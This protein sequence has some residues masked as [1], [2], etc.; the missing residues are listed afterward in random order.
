MDKKRSFLNVVVSIIFKIIVLVVS[1]VARR[2]LIK[3]VGNEVNG[4]NSLYNSIVGFLSVAELGVGVAI[5]Y[6]MYKPIVVK[7]DNKVAALYQ[8]FTKLY[9]IIGAIILIAGCL[10]MSILP[11]LA[12]DYQDANVNIYLTFLLFL[13]SVVIS[14]LFSSKVSLI[15]A[16]KDNYITTAVNSLGLIMQ[17]VLQIVVLI[18]TK[19]FVWYLC[20]HIFATVVQ[21]IAIE[22]ISRK[23]H[24]NIIK[25]KKQKIDA[26]TKKEVVRYVKAMF[27]HKI[28]AVLV[29][30]IDSLIISAFLGV[31]ILG[32][33]S[34]Y[35]TI[36]SAMTG[37]IALFFGPLT[38]IIGHSFLE[39][40][41]E[42]SREYHKA[43]H[44]FN[45]ILAIV[46]FLG[47][48]AVI[49]NLITILLGENLEMV[50]QV[51]F[52]ITLNNFIIFMRQATWLFSD[53]TGVNYYSRWS[54]IVESIFN[55][56]LSILFVIVF[57]KEYNVVGVIVATIMTNLFICHIVEPHVLYKYAF[58]KNAKSYYLC[59]YMY[60]LIFLIAL[61]ALHFSMITTDNQWIE[62]FVNS[63]IS[64]AFSFVI[65]TIIVLFNKDFRSNLKVIFNRFKNRKN[66]AQISNDN[67]QQIA[68]EEN[69]GQTEN[70][71]H[72]EIN[73]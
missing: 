41:A 37:V 71:N 46:F 72:T 42:Q 35:M 39:I 48:Y 9:L 14:Y 70:D 58:R 16:Y 15:N 44:T 43:F 6:C 50:K 22:I 21:G 67:D 8:L 4:L 45:F 24:R 40:G 59:N 62:L 54:P 30:S 63:G 47:Y 49:D 38:S 27:M 66:I 23:K 31:V 7:N 64:L 36:M 53:A 29:S 61:I 56:G 65:S 34:N 19:S 32:K 69:Q 20:C 25:I 18:L 12:K 5:T 10:V 28:G 1:I 52:I 57:P 26:D 13:I 51:S 68:V 33:Y 60:M 2:Y 73:N 11:Y 17:Y 3:C 55:L